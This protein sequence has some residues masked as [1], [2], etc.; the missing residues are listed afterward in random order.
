MYLFCKCVALYCGEVQGE[1]PEPLMKCFKLFLSSLEPFTLLHWPT[2]TTNV[3]NSVWININC[4]L[5]LHL[6]AS[7]VSIYI[8]SFSTTLKVVCHVFSR[9][10]CASRSFGLW[11]DPVDWKSLFWTTQDSKRK[12]ALQTNACLRRYL[13]NVILGGIFVTHNK[14]PLQVSLCW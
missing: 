7:R 14:N 6:C 3:S 1:T 13:W 9:Q 11:L 10:M 4:V 12:E 2:C 8:K 5:L